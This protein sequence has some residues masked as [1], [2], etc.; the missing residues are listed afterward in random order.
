MHAVGAEMGV[1]PL[2]LA[3]GLAGPVL[4]AGAAWRWGLRGAATAYVVGLVLVGCFWPFFVIAGHLLGADPGRMA[5]LRAAAPMAAL[6]VS[7]AWAVC[8]LPVLAIGLVRA[9]RRTT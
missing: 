8:A 1:A 4:T 6:N 3:A 2:I 5:H 9:R 7:A